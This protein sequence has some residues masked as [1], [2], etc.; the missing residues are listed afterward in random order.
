LKNNKHE[1][2]FC[3]AQQLDAINFLVSLARSP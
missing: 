2:L 1:N 3:L